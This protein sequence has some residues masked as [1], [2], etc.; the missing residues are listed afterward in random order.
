MRRVG[1]AS[2]ALAVTRRAPAVVA[3]AHAR[4]VCVR[5]WC[6][7][8]QRRRRVSTGEGDAA[9]L[10]PTPSSS[11]MGR[12]GNLA[13]RDAGSGNA[14][15]WQYRKEVTIFLLALTPISFFSRYTRIEEPAAVVFDEHHFG[16]FVN[17]YFTGSYFFDI[18]P[19]LAK[20]VRPR[21]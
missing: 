4:R 12:R 7:C 20:L 17:R 15:A 13:D 21:R 6:D 2:G 19:P 16:R 3:Y 10:E 1:I 5:V 9:E 18:H 8:V 11:A 14:A